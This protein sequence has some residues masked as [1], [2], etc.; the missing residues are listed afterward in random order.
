MLSMIF[1]VAGAIIGLLAACLWL[2]ASCINW[3]VGRQGR[4]LGDYSQHPGEFAGPNELDLFLNPSGNGISAPP[5]RRQYPCC[6]GRPRRSPIS[7]LAIER[8]R[9]VPQAP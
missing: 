9:C 2:R 8:L 5:S 4:L 7:M 6:A 3:N 1:G